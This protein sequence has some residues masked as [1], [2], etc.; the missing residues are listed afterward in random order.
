MK[1]FEGIMQMFLLVVSVVAFAYLVNE[2]FSDVRAETINVNGQEIE[3]DSQ[4]QV[5]MIQWLV[6]HGVDVGNPDAIANMDEDLLNEF[7]AEFGEVL[8]GGTGGTPSQFGSGGNVRGDGINFE[9]GFLGRLNS[10]TGG[11]TA[12]CVKTKDNKICQEYMIKDCEDKCSGECHELIYSGG[13]FNEVQ[14]S[15]V[16][17]ECELGYCYDSSNGVCSV[18]GSPRGKCGEDGG[19]WYSMSDAEGVEWW[20]RNC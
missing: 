15:G 6:Q 18:G 4:T 5:E 16:P 7:Y 20:E 11:G 19:K 17:S 1:K 9:G 13:N 12:M 3:L 10:L 2:G 8:G 14:V